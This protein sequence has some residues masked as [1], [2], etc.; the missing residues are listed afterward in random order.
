MYEA[1]D[2]AIVNGS[3]GSSTASTLALTCS[4]Q[5]LVFQLIHIGLRYCSKPCAIKKR[6]SETI[7]SIIGKICQGRR[8]LRCHFELIYQYVKTQVNKIMA[9]VK[10][11]G[12]LGQ[13]VSPATGEKKSSS[14]MQGYERID[15]CTRMLQAI[16]THHREVGPQNYFY[17][18]GYLSGILLNSKPLQLWPFVKVSSDT[19]SSFT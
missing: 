15:Y 11:H 14:S 8:F 1:D 13:Q 9:R 17:F 16:V 19:S 7:L 2:K 4:S 18:S 3:K 10:A 6:I 5:D 12:L